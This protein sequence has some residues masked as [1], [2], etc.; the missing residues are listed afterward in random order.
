MNN[1]FYLSFIPI[2]V[3][4]GWRGYQYGKEKLYEYVMSEVKKELDKRMR[5]EDDQELF[6]P[7]ERC[8]SAIIKVTHGGKS[9][10]I[11]IPYDRS[12][13]TSMLM[14]KV[15]L[16]RDGQE[17]ELSQKPGVPFLVSAQDLGGDKI[18]LKDFSGEHLHEYTA[19]EVPNF[20]NPAKPPVSPSNP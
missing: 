10:N 2:S 12:K 19:N 8:K 18:I 6:K 15:Y 7:H 17:I 14:R 11:F 5:D 16:I 9:H 3:Y 1:Y 20:L 13:S 4:I